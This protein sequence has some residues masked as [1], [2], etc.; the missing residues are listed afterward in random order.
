[1]RAQLLRI[2]A[3]LFLTIILCIAV[4]HWV[5]RAN[6]ELIV[7][8]SGV[9]PTNVFVAVF[10]Q[11]WKIVPLK[12]DGTARFDVEGPDSRGGTTVIVAVIKDDRILWEG[13]LRK[14]A[15]RPR[16]EI[17]V[18]RRSEFPNLPET[19]KLELERTLRER[20]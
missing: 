11:T 12:S 17:P 6:K 7:E 20:E 1:M 8:V 2:A 19:L 10:E 15:A 16:I 3:L 9:S 13:V 18:S 5:Y 14:S 4:R